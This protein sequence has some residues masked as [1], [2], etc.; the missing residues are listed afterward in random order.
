M[1]RDNFGRFVA[2]SDLETK[3][4]RR[5]R[6]LREILRSHE[7]FQDRSQGLKEAKAKILRYFVKRSQ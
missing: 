7:D 2:N 4:K 5:D 3:Q 1:K 6:D